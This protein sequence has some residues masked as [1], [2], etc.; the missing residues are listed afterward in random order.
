[1]KSS[2]SL[3]VSACAVYESSSF[4]AISHYMNPLMQS[5]SRP[6]TT[7]SCFVPLGVGHQ[8]AKHTVLRSATVGRSDTRGKRPSRS[9]R[10]P[11]INEQLELETIR[12]EL[13]QKYLSFGHSLEDAT[14][15]VEYFLEDEERS[16]DYVEM[17]RVAMARGNDLG[18][19]MIVQ[20]G[21]AFLLGMAGSWLI[22]SWDAYQASNPG[23]LPWIS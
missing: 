10:T 2:L 16:A 17:R 22:H 9:R 11:T 23:G 4:V 21:G 3:I 12:K 6:S 1:M 5:P 14:R 19:E 8:C 15:E 13:I 20:F 18:I 7:P